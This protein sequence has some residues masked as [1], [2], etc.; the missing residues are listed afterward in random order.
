[1]ERVKASEEKAMRS[2]S[3]A[4]RSGSMG[5]ICVEDGAG[6]CAGDGS[7]CWAEVEVCGGGGAG[8]RDAV[9][10]LRDLGRC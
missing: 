9:L 10:S 4:A 7:G 1:M 8:G 2:A 6:V 5:F 3:E